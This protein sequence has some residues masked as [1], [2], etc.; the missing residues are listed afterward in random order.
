[1]YSGALTLQSSS[2]QIKWIDGTG[3]KCSTECAN[4]G[5]GEI[6][7]RNFVFIAFLKACFTRGDELLEVLKGSKVDSTVRKH[8]NKT[9]GKTTIEGADPT[10]EPHLASSV[11]DQRSTVKAAFPSLILDTA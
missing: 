4:A 9:H 10:G 3:A 2:K 1:M 7:E 6:T 5:G 8:A 11:E